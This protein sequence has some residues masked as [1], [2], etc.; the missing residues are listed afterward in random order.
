MRP[1]EVRNT[2]FRDLNRMFRGARERERSQWRHTLAVCQTVINFGGPRSNTWKPK[3]L[4]YMW[5]E[6][7]GD[8][9]AKMDD[10]RNSIEKAKA[11]IKERENGD[12]SRTAG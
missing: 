5:E 4:F 9:K 2:G 6:I 3:H 8:R 1:D 7:F 10:I 11:A 12:S